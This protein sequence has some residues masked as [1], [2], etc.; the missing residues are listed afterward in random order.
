MAM[1]SIKFHPATTTYFLP[2]LHLYSC[3]PK[4]CA[5]SLSHRSCLNIGTFAIIR[6]HVPAIKVREKK[7]WYTAQTPTYFSVCFGFASVDDWFIR[8][9]TLP[10]RRTPVE[11]GPSSQAD[12]Q[13]CIF[14]PTV[15]TYSLTREV[16]QRSSADFIL[17]PTTTRY[18]IHRTI[19]WTTVATPAKVVSV[20]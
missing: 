15:Y 3:C 10:A 20:E 8:S 5:A 12:S 2:S 4:N 11:L 18:T 9:T 19:W 6:D 17:V 1:N 14:H 7:L 16:P 13:S